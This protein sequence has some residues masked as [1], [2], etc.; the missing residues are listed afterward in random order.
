MGENGHYIGYVYNKD[1]N[2]FFQ[3]DALGQNFSKMRNHKI[4]EGFLLTALLYVLADDEDF[5]TT[6]MQNNIIDYSLSQNS[7]HYHQ[8]TITTITLPPINHHY[9]QSPIIT[10]TQTSQSHHH[11]H[12]TTITI[13]PSSPPHHHH[14]STITTI[15]YHN[16][17][18]R[19]MQK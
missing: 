9:H 14:N 10:T 13:P 7:P 1:A 16:H 19:S 8:S 5:D 6:Q 15:T 4:P 18:S 17:S 11:H 12:H 2:S 3:Y